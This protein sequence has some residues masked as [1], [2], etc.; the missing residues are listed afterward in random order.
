MI[1]V[2]SSCRARA[3][4]VWG[5]VRE[6]R[7]DQWIEVCAVWVVTALSAVLYL[8]ALSRNGMGNSYY[9]AA[10]KSATVSWKALLFGSL[11]PGSFITV[12][13]PPFAFW[14]QGLSG[15]LFGFSS[16]SMLLP[17]ALAGVATVLILYRIVRRWMGRNAAVLAGLVMAL[18]PV[19]V[20]IFRLNN[21]DAL[22]TL[23]LVAA[24]W[25]LWSALERGSTW[26][27]VTAGVLMGFAFTTK[28]LEGLIV[29]PAFVVVY[30]VFGKRSIWRRAWQT[31]AA[32]AALVAAGSWWVVLV[33][34]W[35]ADSRPFIGGSSDNS[36]F[37]LIF[38]RTGGYF[39]NLPSPSFSG[40]AGVLRMFNAQLGGQISWLLPLALFG[41]SAGLWVYRRSARSDLR[42]AGF[43]LFGLWTLI[44]VAVF[45]DARGVLH[46]YYTV[47]LAPSVAALV[48]GGSVVL[49]RLSSSK[50]WLAWLLPAG[51][52]GSVVWSYSLLGRTPGYA[53]GLA[54]AIL[55]MGILAAA[56]LFLVLSG[57]VLRR[58]VRYSVAVII[59][60]CLLAGPFAYALSTLARSVTGPF[61]A[62]GPVEVASAGRPFPGGDGQVASMGGMPGLPGPYQSPA[63]SGEDIAADA[64]LVSYLVQHKGTADYLVAVQGANAAVPIILATGQPVV[65]MGGFSGSDPAP[66]LAQLQA[67]VS[68]GKLHHVLVGGASGALG[69]VGGAP[70]MDG[71]PGTGRSPGMGGFGGDPSSAVGP[72]AGVLPGGV[73]SSLA[74]VQWVAEN[75]TLVSSDE[76]GGD[77]AGTLYYLS[78]SGG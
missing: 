1:S 53:T 49:W 17:Q 10:A 22:L 57:I 48:G 2:L 78:P 52:V 59:T 29:L 12:D 38:S 62:A 9:A 25:A 68:A 61:A 35:P 71:S 64:S 51:V 16:W 34:L 45:S 50:T 18:T 69:G 11:D 42:R 36:V 40:S 76:Y 14:I 44:F 32:G 28:M 4:T 7:R 54:P 56:V 72:N 41:L 70:G 8:W 20:V 33:Q 24:A 63:A 65:A 77:A 74:I 6:T 55:V 3:H 67:L 47:V 26:K 43:V 75:G 23:L 31:L 39:D 19:A 30:L 21:P 66:S 60:L 37:G 46:P 58:A 27:L 73:G 13:K 15:R 5:A